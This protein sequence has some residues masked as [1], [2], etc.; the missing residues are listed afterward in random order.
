MPEPRKVLWDQNTGLAWW[1]GRHRQGRWCVGVVGGESAGEPVYSMSN[2]CMQL[3][4]WGTSHRGDKD[5]T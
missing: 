1:R 2:L 5:G 3:A 4:G